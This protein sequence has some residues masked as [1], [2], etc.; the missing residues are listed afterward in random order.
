MPCVMDGDKLRETGQREIPARP[1]V[2]RPAEG[3]HRSRVS[4]VTSVV[5]FPIVSLRCEMELWFGEKNGGWFHGGKAGGNGHSVRG[6]F[7]LH[8]NFPV[9]S[10]HWRGRNSEG[11]TSSFRYRRFWR[12][13]KFSSDTQPKVSSEAVAGS[14]TAVAETLSKYAV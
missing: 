7:S 5:L 2:D 11:R 13:R 9:G 4:A 12:R 14:G 3:V 6:L 1:A 10:S 8:A